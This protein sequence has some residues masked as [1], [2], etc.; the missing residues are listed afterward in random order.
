[1]LL[2]VSAISIGITLLLIHLIIEIDKLDNVLTPN[3]KPINYD[4][5]VNDKFVQKRILSLIMKVS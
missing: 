3:L 5:G 1:M 4:L 2:I